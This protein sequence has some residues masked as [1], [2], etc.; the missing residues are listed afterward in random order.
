M[1]SPEALLVVPLVLGY[2]VLV[3]T[4]VYA[5][6]IATDA[7]PRIPRARAGPRSTRGG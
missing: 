3:A 5:R 2:V 4:L 6:W 1:L 7:R